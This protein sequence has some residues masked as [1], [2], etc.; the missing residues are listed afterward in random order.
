MKLPLNKKI[1]SEIPLFYGD[2][3]MPNGFEIN[4]NKLLSDI[5]LHEINN[6]T[7]PFSKEWD[8]LNTFLREHIY[9]EYGY[10]LVNKLTKGTYFKP[11]TIS[12]GYLEINPIDLKN[13][14]DFVMLYGVNIKKDTLQ[15]KIEYDDNRRKGRTLITNI[16]NNSFII[17]PSTQRYTIQSNQT[18]S[19][20][21][22]L[23]ITYEYI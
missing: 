16:N 22:L 6:S 14:P 10:T 15:V 5:I 19:L 9:V 7:F 4:R 3:K 13:S 18:D 17:F 11:N 23:T 8:K 20:N 2:I 21:F 12:P 1:L